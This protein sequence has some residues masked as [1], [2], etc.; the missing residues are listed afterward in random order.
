[1]RRR[2]YDSDPNSLLRFLDIKSEFDACCSAGF[3]SLCESRI[4]LP[5]LLSALLLDIKEYIA[6]PEVCDP[7][8]PF[9]LTRLAEGSAYAGYPKALMSGREGFLPARGGEQPP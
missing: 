9:V 1:M 7:Q 4:S 8:V 5:S 2:W 3:Y 6:T